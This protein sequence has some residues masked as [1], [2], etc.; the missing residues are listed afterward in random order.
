MK[1]LNLDDLITEKPVVRFAPNPSGYLHIGHARAAILNDEIAKQYNGKMILRIEDTDP[2]RVDIESYE[3]I[4]EDLKWL[5][6]NWSEKIIQS[7]RLKIY[8]QACLTLLKQ[9]NAYVCNCDTEK[10]KNLKLRHQICPHRNLSINENLGNFSIMHNEEGW[11]V[12]AKTNIGLKNSSLI[13]FPILRSSSV[14]HPRLKNKDLK[15]YPLMNLSVTVDDHLLGITHVLRGKDH[16]MN[17]EKQKFLYK[18]FGW[19][20]PKFI[21]YGI[22]SI[23]NGKISKSE[24]KK[25]IKEGIYTGWDDVNLLT[26]RALRRRGISP[27]AIRDYIIDIGVKDADTTLSEEILYFENKKYVEKSKRYFFVDN[28]IKLIVDEFPNLKLRMPLHKDFDYGFRSY[29]LNPDKGKMNFLIRSEDITKIKVGEELRLMNLCN[30]VITK[31]D[32]KVYADYVK[33]SHS[34]MAEVDGKSGEHKKYFKTKKILWIPE[35]NNLHA[36]I[37]K[38]GV[39]PYLEG[40]CEIHCKNLVKDEII[41]FESFGFCRVDEIVKD[42]NEKIKELKFYFGHR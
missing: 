10:F 36:K 38:P 7:D 9:G 6:I 2:K 24:I 35:N 32:D 40:V 22:M 30:I 26:L 28:P 20:T 39:K 12:R 8:E 19:K 31:I 14:K 42:E 25:G 11:V 13:D 4:E 1:K 23:G 33:D 21:H 37:F 27:L 3:T 41:Q 16:L 18:F 34:P 29:I 17:T 15:I 5:N